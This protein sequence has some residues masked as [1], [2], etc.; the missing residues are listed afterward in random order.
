MSSHPHPHNLVKFRPV[1]TLEQI[2]HII[3]LTE[4]PENM[5]D[6]DVNLNKSLK[7]VLVPMIAKIETGA[8]NPAYKLSETKIIKDAERLERERYEND[9]MSPEE[10]AE[11]ELKILGY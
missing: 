7:R 3:S 1:L 11:Y 9:L 6:E 8:I 2:Q 4:R 10:S 5:N